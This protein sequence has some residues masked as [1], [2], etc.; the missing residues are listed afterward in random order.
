MLNNLIVSHGFAKA[1]QYTS[2]LLS[3]LLVIAFTLIHP[4]LPP[5]KGGAPPPSAKKIFSSVPFVFLVV[6]FFCVSMGLYFPIYYLQVGSNFCQQGLPH[7]NFPLPPVPFL[8][9]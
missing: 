2:I 1:V 4:R 3:L 6:G 8:S 7:S 5:K 9:S